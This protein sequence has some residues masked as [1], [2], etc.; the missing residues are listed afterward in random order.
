M[1]FESCTPFGRTISTGL[2]MHFQIN[3]QLPAIHVTITKPGLTRDSFIHSF[4]FCL[5]VQPSSSI[6]HSVVAEFLGFDTVGFITL[7]YN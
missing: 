1:F 4:H 2:I 6:L 5:T 7:S 3:Y